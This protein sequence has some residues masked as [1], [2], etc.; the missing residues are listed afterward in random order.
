[1]VFDTMREIN[2]CKSRYS[3]II[4]TLSLVSYKGSLVSRP[5]PFYTLCAV[6][7]SIIEADQKQLVMSQSSRFVTMMVPDKC[8][9]RCCH[10]SNLLEKFD[11]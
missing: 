10:C 7:N 4:L 2:K 9:K 6:L 1:M 8:A 3:G 5:H 11:P